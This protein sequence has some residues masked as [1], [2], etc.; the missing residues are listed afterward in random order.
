MR[1]SPIFAWY[2][3]WVGIYWDSKNRWLYFFPIPTVGLIFK[4][5]RSTEEVVRDM[6]AGNDARNL[7]IDMVEEEI[8]EEARDEAM[9]ILDA[10]TQSFREEFAYYHTLEQGNQCCQVLDYA[11]HELVKKG[12]IQKAD[13]HF[14]HIP[15][16][17][18]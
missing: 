17:D 12:M 1:V 5:A 14:G 18:P 15:G 3:F 6:L 7:L 16:I 11:K 13:D 4:F 2:D 10:T 9:R 8:A